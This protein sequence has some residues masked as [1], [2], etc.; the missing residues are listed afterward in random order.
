MFKVITKFNWYEK[1]KNQII[2]VDLIK[3]MGLYSN[4]YAYY[5]K[6]LIIQPA[7]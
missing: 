4:K 2:K 6:K 5:L 3:K 7:L 1:T